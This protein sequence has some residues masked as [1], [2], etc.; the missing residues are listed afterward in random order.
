[1]AEEKASTL[2]PPFDPEK[3]RALMSDWLTRQKAALDAVSAK[4]PKPEK[5]GDAAELWRS[6]MEF[7]N[8]LSKVMPPQAGAQESGGGLQCE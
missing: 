7:W 1:M 8:I 5:G 2:F 3:A 4:F 6:Y